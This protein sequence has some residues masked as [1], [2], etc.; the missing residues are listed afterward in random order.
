MKKQ[1][2]KIEEPTEVPVYFS[3]DEFVVLMQLLD[4]AVKSYGM[5][6]AEQAV[7]F[8]QKFRGAIIKKD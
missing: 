4:M 6:V 3:N 8:Q 2:V 1:D 5:Q 7:Y